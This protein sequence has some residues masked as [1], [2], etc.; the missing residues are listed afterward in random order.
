MYTYWVNER[1]F[2][3]NHGFRMDF[4]LINGELRQRLSAV[5]VDSGHRGR[6]KPSDHAAV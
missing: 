2:G 4:I 1:A 5:G 6:E 3:A